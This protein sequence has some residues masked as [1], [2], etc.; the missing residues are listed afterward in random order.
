[1]PALRST[2]VDLFH[3]FRGG[4]GSVSASANAPHSRRLR[5]GLLIVEAAFA[6]VL[7]VGASLLAHSSLQLMRVYAGYGAD[8]MSV[9]RVQLREGNVLDV[10]SLAFITLLLEGIRATRV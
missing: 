6:V 4:E 10:R 5:L 2:R 3:A 9:M 1:V 8:P 7:A